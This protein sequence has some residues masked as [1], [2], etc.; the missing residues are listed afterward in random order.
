MVFAVPIWQVLEIQVNMQNKSLTLN[1]WPKYG[2]RSFYIQA[3]S[4]AVLR[5]M[6]EMLHQELRAALEQA[7]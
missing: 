2:K 6:E 1:V 4:S 5:G 3:S 7:A